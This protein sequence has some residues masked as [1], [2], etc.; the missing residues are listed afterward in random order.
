MAREKTSRNSLH[1]LQGCWGNTAVR[2]N[3]H[4]SLEAV[5]TAQTPTNSALLTFH[6]SKLNPSQSVKELSSWGR[7]Q[8][9]RRQG[10]YSPRVADDLPEFLQE[11]GETSRKPEAGSPYSR[12]ERTGGDEEGERSKSLVC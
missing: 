9:H 4:P 1:M 10:T 6:S 3:V 5:T 8:V 2:S 11:G 12:S 7:T